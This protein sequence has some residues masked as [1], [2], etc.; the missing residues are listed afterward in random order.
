MSGGLVA[1]PIGL[2]LIIPKLPSY[3]KFESTLNIILD[4]YA[5]YSNKENQTINGYKEC[6]EILEDDGFF[7]TCCFG[8]KTDGFGTGK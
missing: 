3:S 6:F 7:L 2:L 1:I 8:K 5:L 4:S